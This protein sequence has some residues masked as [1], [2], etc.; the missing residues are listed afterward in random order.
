MAGENEG[1]W[2]FWVF[3]RGDDPGWQS[4]KSINELW[5]KVL[6]TTFCLS[7]LSHIMTQ[8]LNDNFT[9]L[10][11]PRHDIKSAHSLE[12]SKF[13]KDL[14][15]ATMNCLYFAS[16]KYFWSSISLLDHIQACFYPVSQSLSIFLFLDFSKQ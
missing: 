4:I 15:I 2:K 1:G 14:S 11:L 6:A 7:S 5:L 3:P 16:D 13:F 9:L 12:Y 10:S 8:Y